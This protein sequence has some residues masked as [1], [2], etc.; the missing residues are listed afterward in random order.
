MEF[1][2]GKTQ[3]R[4]RHQTI[5]LA[6]PSPTGRNP[7]TLPGW[8][9]TITRASV[10]GTRM[11][12][13]KPSKAEPSF[14]SYGHR[15]SETAKAKLIDLLGY[16]KVD[17]LEESVCH[18]L[19]GMKVLKR[20]PGA[21]L[22]L[23]H[24]P[25]AKD[26][27]RQ[28]NVGKIVLD[29]ETALGIYIDG[30]DHIDRIPRP[31]DYIATFK[32][33]R[34]DAAKLLNALTALTEYYRGQ[35]K[36]KAADINAIEQ[37]LASLVDTSNAV[38]REMEVRSSKGARRNTALTEVTRHLKRIFRG[39]YRGPATGRKKR[40]AVVQSA[41]WENRQ[42]D[43][44]RTALIDGRCIPR[45]YKDTELQR[46][47]RNPRCSLPSER[48]A[49]LERLARR[50]GRRSAPYTF[51]EPDPLRAARA[52]ARGARDDRLRARQQ[53]RNAR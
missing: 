40:G 44:I 36:Q 11:P 17:L 53:K 6:A 33:I 21:P 37:S 22:E 27:A 10:K 46:L 15:L 19:P 51:P 26:A 49:V 12:R 9:G 4:R 29:V 43:F 20:E 34:R 48:N 13:V 39:N 45:T 25:N 8:R 16:G 52:Q 18:Q 28:M 41:D 23:A 14:T 3:D 30:A 32:P 2:A 7:G 24:D 47:I 38:L 1:R 42:R 35:F 5:E 31:A 50:A